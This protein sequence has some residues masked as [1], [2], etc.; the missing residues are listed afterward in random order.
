M[1][2]DRE[3]KA[4]NRLLEMLIK[5]KLF[6]N[7]TIIGDAL[8]A[9]EL[10]G[11][12]IKGCPGWDILCICKTGCNKAAFDHIEGVQHNSVTINVKTEKD[13]ATWKTS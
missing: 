4:A 9:N 13:R 2:Q 10:I 7:A 3:N 8:H 1:K 5:L 12:Q 6:P 11:S